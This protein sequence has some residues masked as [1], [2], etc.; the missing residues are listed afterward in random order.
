[1]GN[2]SNIINSLKR[3]ERV[4]SETSIV[5]TK[6]KK[7]VETIADKLENEISPLFDN[8]D[9]YDFYLITGCLYY[10]DGNLYYD[11][12][13][14]LSLDNIEDYALVPGSGLVSRKTALEFA[15]AVSEKNLLNGVIKWIEERWKKRSRYSY[16]F[17]VRFGK[18]YPNSK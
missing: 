12:D 18:D 14:D 17:C 4:G 2:N 5:T 8:C 1:M 3:L 7:A 9:E 13:G 11:Y 6:L 10:R 15:H 16:C